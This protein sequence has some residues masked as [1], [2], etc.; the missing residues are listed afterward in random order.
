MARQ[1][2]PKKA[3]GQHFLTDVDI[4]RRIASTSEEYMGTPIIEVGPGLGV[5]TKHLIEDK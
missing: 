4:A 3:L 5:L 2:R 1:V